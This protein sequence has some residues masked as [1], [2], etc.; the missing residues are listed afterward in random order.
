MMDR[1]GAPAR[2][3]FRVEGMTCEHCVAAVRAEV[4]ALAGVS[5]V[6]VELESGRVLVSGSGVESDAVR[7]AIEE[8]GYS[9]AA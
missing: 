1:V 2:Q 4:G 6:E 7:G 8:A 5:D 9:L 3:V